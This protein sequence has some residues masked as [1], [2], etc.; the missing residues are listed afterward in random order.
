M[1]KSHKTFGVKNIVHC[2]PHFAHNEYS[3]QTLDYVT[4]KKN[5]EMNKESITCF[6]PLLTP[7]AF[8]FCCHR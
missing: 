7:A 2:V 4:E 3:E 1:Y 6:I 5:I 8:G